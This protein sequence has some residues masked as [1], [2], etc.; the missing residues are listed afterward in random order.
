[1]ETLEQLKTIRDNAPD[2]ATHI[3][4]VDTYWK[5]VSELDYYFYNG[6]HWD[7]SEPLKNATRSLSDIERIIELME[8]S[9]KGEY[10]KQECKHPMTTASYDYVT[11]DSC[12][13]IKTDG[14]WGCA[15]GKWFD[16]VESAKFYERNG[17]LPK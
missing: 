8:Q 10:T 17:F 9:S 12:G 16:N 4:D 6:S 15:S 5:V 7:V 2:G 3:Y 11:C 14:G 13:M 1:M